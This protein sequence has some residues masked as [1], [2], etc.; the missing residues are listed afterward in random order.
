MKRTVI[1]T[2][3]ILLLFIASAAEAMIWKKTGINPFRKGSEAYSEKQLKR[4]IKGL[5]AMDLDQKIVE[6][7]ISDHRTKNNF[8]WKK[9]KT[10]DTFE[11]MI[12]GDYVIWQEVVVG[13]SKNKVLAAKVYAIN[14]QYELWYPLICGNWS[15]KKIF[16]PIV[17]GLPPVPVFTQTKLELPTV[18]VFTQKKLGLPP[19]PVFKQPQ[20]ELPSVP[21]FIGKKVKNPCGFDLY[22]GGGI[23]ETDRWLNKNNKDYHH[24][25][26]YAWT[27]AR[28]RPYGFEVTDRISACFGAFAFGAIGSGD[29]EGYDYNWKKW[30]IGP[31]LKLIGYK[32]HWDADFDL[33]LWGQ[34]VSKGNID[35]YN[36]KQIDDI[37]VFSAHLNLYERRVKEKKWFPKTE[38]NFEFTLPHN[39]SHEHD[40]DGNMLNPDP[41]D[42]QVLEILWT[43]HVYD[44]EIGKDLLLTPGFNL[45]YVKE[46]GLNNP[47]FLQFGPRATLTW[48]NEDILTIS[49]LNYKENLGGDG[50]QWHWLSGYFSI[51]GLRNA[52][53][54]S[55]ITEPTEKE[56]C[57]TCL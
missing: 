37:S 27:K 50:D 4:D 6:S 54:S 16:K 39:K 57:S 28:Y 38:F 1:L 15:I 3:V 49:A 46:F 14:D 35:L 2:M 7:I 52:Y 10:G 33:G 32:D 25:G 36:S 47:N 41:S 24:S 11:K 30:S 22:V 17:M 44:F 21:V 9:I 5:I 42:N 8:Q 18:P 45:A 12:F 13:F 23:Y 51:I 53:K 56:L 19:V 40:W 43:Q 29:D 48:Q 26:W 34:H 55:Q 31:S 20:K